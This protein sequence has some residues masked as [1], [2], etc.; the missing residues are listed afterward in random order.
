M[1]RSDVIRR[2]YTSYK[3]QKGMVKTKIRSCDSC[4]VRQVGK[5]RIIVSY[6]IVIL[7]D[8]IIPIP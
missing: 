3:R 5:S 8:L 7:V 6:T 2:R 1:K 4:K